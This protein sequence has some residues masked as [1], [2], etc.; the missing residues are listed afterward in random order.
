MPPSLTPP[1]HILRGLPRPLR[2]AAAALYWDGFGHLLLPF[3]ADRRRGQAL[4]ASSL[5]PEQALV[6]LSPA[7]ALIG[8]MG[9]RGVQGGFLSPTPARFRRVWGP[10]RGRACHLATRLWRPGPAT[11]DLI[12]DGIIIAPEWRKRGICRALLAHA[13]QIAAERGHPG[14]RVEVEAANQPALS[15]YAAL[16]FQPVTRARAGWA[17]TRHPAHILRRPLAA[18]AQPR[19]NIPETCASSVKARPERV[20]A[21]AASMSSP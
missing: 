9:W 7:G 19:P 8:L 5:N 10:M 17:W 16:G 1:F 6:A 12:V 15:A 21:S 4:V 3:A 18:A 14:L 20:S 11:S 13:G 2:P